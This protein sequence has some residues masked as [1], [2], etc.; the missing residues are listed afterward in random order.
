MPPASLPAHLR[1]KS[2]GAEAFLVL[3]SLPSTEDKCISQR[4]DGPEISRSSTGEAGEG[5]G[6][7]A[8]SVSNV[9]GREWAF[10]PPT[11]PY[12][13]FVPPCLSAR[14]RG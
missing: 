4:P 11:K 1:S 2:C 8:L 7:F 6:E 13:S 3:Y 9:R 14:A 10:A 5:E 12:L